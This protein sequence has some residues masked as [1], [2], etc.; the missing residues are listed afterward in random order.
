M[1]AG[2]HQSSV[3]FSQVSASFSPQPETAVF[4]SLPAARVTDRRPHLVF[5]PPSCSVPLLPFPP[6]ILTA[7]KLAQRPATPVHEIKGRLTPRPDG[8]GGTQQPSAL[9]L[10]RHAQI[11]LQPVLWT[12]SAPSSSVKKGLRPASLSP[13]LR[14]RS[15]RPRCRTPDPR[16]GVDPVVRASRS[17]LPRSSLSPEP[18]PRDARTTPGTGLRT[19]R[20]LEAPSPSRYGRAGR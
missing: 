19:F 3:F 6:F 11:P 14:S 2:A 7:H 5:P 20:E 12:P 8:T 13:D 1:R 4:T 9:L 17:R 15:P 16:S 10:S 18:G